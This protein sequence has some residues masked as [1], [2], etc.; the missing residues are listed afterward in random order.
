MKNVYDP[1]PAWMQ[2][3]SVE[4]DHS[5]FFVRLPI[6]SEFLSTSFAIW[7]HVYIPAY[8]ST[9]RP[10]L[11]QTSIEDINSGMKTRDQSTSQ[12]KLQRDREPARTIFIDSFMIRMSTSMDAGFVQNRKGILTVN[13]VAVPEIV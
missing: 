11:E 7:I 1:G 5:S 3:P 4:V 6:P 13:N 8:S 9:S 2:S 12:D 10:L